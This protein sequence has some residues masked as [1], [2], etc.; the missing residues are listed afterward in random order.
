MDI[1]H[2]S[3]VRDVYGGTISLIVLATIAVGARLAA[4]RLSV[5]NLW[6]DDWTIVLALVTYLLFSISRN[7]RGRHTVPAGGPVDEAD[8]KVFFKIFLAVQILYLCSAAAIKTSLVLLYYRIFGVIRW[9]RFVLATAL[10]VVF[11]YFIVCVLIAI[12]ECQPVGFYWDKSIQGGKCIDQ[13]QFYRWNGVANLLI[14]FLI[15]SLT[16]LVIW[17]LNLSLRQKI[18]LSVIFA[19]GLLACAA[20]IVR[21]V[22]FN[23]V[24]TEDITYTLVTATI[25]TTIEQSVGIICACL[26]A[27]KPLMGRLFSNIRSGGKGPSDNTPDAHIQAISLPTYNSRRKHS[28][29]VDNSMAGFTRLEEGNAGAVGAGLVT[30]NASRISREDLPTVPDRIV[31][32]HKLEQRIDDKV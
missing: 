20:S 3:N 10:T 32:Q 21:V 25:W 11:L 6:W 12:L 18:S 19:L 1:Y 22:A 2:Q 5:A 7:V 15:W 28:G 9:F 16:L 17:H 24:K 31:T 4:R 29:S 26:P 13:Y 30:T 14:D 23:Q 8:L 27:T